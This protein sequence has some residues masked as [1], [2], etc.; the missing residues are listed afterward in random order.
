MPYLP[1]QSTT[2]AFFNSVTSK[3]LAVASTPTNSLAIMLINILTD[4]TNTVTS[5]TDDKGNTYVVVG[6][7]D[8]PDTRNYV[9]YGVH[10]VGGVTTITVNFSGSASVGY[11]G[12]D[13][14]SGAYS[15]NAATIDVS[16]TEQSVGSSNYSN[17]TSPLVPTV[18][19]NL[20]YLCLLSGDDRIM[21]AGT[22]FTGYMGDGLSYSLHGQY[23]LSG[24]TSESC[25]A[26]LNGTTQWNVFAFSFK[27]APPVPPIGK[28]TK[29]NQAINRASN[30]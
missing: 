17:L 18:N 7:L 29:P 26:S 24:T 28:I 25:P 6:P 11:I 8:K 22:G 12:A 15:T 19:G 1:I 13:L 20:I 14:F 2:R 27:P 30:Y 5:V 9:A 23:K 3:D 21:T 16:T 10:A 4:F